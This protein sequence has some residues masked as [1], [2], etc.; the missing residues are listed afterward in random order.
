MRRSPLFSGVL[1]IIFGAF[2]IYFAVHDLQ[3]NQE[4]GFYTYLL[5]ILATFDI[6]SGIKLINFHF[7]L[8]KTNATLKTKTIIKSVGFCWKSTSKNFSKMRV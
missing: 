1:Y 2:F 7:F 6:G 3:R 5:V 4:W 8:K